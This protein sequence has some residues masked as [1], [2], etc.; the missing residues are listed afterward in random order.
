MATTD[1]T[2]PVDW[3]VD[4]VVHFLCHPGPAPWAQSSN[5]PRP[6]SAKLEATLRDNEMCGEVLMHVDND[7]LKDMG[8]K[9]YGHRIS[10]MKAVRW[11]QDKSPKYKSSQR[12]NHE[13]ETPEVRDRTQTDH[14]K[15]VPVA[16]TPVIVVP[17][18]PSV[19]ESSIVDNAQK[20]KRRIAPS[21]VQPDITSNSSGNDILSNTFAAQSGNFQPPEILA[22]LG[23]KAP[24]GARTQ[25]EEDF[26]EYLTQKYHDDDDDTSSPLPL[27]G[28]SESEGELDNETYRAI[29][30]DNPSLDISRPILPREQCKALIAEY[31]AEKEQL[32]R[33]KSLP[34][35]L[36]KARKMWMHSRQSNNLEREKNRFSADIAHLE[37]RLM[38][39]QE[40]ILA[41]EYRSSQTLQKACKN[42]DPTISDR[43]LGKWKL[44]TLESD[45]CPSKIPHRVNNTRARVIREVDSG[46]DET[47]DSGTE[48]LT[49]DSL[50]EEMS[51]D[52]VDFDQ[53]DIEQV[54]LGHETVSVSI[55]S[56]NENSRAQSKEL[57]PEP[58]PTRGFPFSL[59]SSP[60]SSDSEPLH[61]LRKR[62]RV[63]E[64]G[65]S[66]HANP[67]LKAPPTA[68]IQ[69]DEDEE[70]LLDMDI[71]PAANF[72]ARPSSSS[73]S[74]QQQQDQDIAETLIKTPPL[75][76]VSPT[77]NVDRELMVKTPPLNPTTPVKLT[78]TRPRPPEA[79]STKTSPSS[80]RSS[81]AR[82][83][84]I[85]DC[86]S[87]GSPMQEI[88]SP[89]DIEHA[90]LF[91]LLNGTSM[92]MIMESKDRIQLLAKSV[93]Q[94]RSSEIKSFGMFLD[95]WFPELYVEG[96]QEAIRAMIQNKREMQ[97][98]D[99]ED[100]KLFMRLAAL[101]VSWFHCVTL[102]PS[103]IDENLLDQALKAIKPGAESTFEIFY[104]K[105]KALVHAYNKWNPNSS[106]RRSTSV[107]SPNF[108]FRFENHSHRTSTD[109]DR[110]K[111]KRRHVIKLQ[112]NAQSFAQDRKAK[113]DRAREAFRRDR[114]RL[115]LSNSDPA[116]QVV[117]FKE[118]ILYLNPGIGEFVK[119][120]QLLG[121]QFMW[122][123]L[124]EGDNMQGCLLAHVMGL[125]KTMQVISLLVTIAEAAASQNPKI[126][127]QVP[128]K[129]H[130]SQTL[131]LCP[132]SLSHN[133]LE[134]LEFWAPPDHYLG[135]FYDINPNFYTDAPTRL[136]ILEAWKNN[137]GIL[138]LSYDMFRR[139]MSSNSSNTFDESQQKIVDN[140]LLSTPSIVVADEAHRLKSGVSAISKAASR[141]KTTS[142]IA[143]TGS[144][145]ANNLME[146]FQMIDWIAPGYLETSSAFKEK[147]VE[148]IQAG[149]YLDSTRSQRR[150]GLIALKL[151]NMIM[152][153]KVNRASIS[154]IAS[155]LPTK[156]EFILRVPLTETQKAAYNMFVQETKFNGNLTTLWQWLAIMQLCC[157]HPVPFLEK[158]KDRT[159]QN[160]DSSSF[161]PNSI[162]E[163]GLPS[164]LFQKIETIFKTVP[165]LSDPS[166]SHRAV[167]LGRI[168]EESKKVGDKV[169]IFTQSIPTV[170]YLDS[171][172]KE[173]HSS[174]KRIDGSTPTY[175]RQQMTKS[176]N[177][178]DD[179]TQV[180]LISTRAGGLGLNMFGA[181]RVIIFDFLFNPTWE[182]QAIGRAYRLGQMKPV[183]VYRFVAAGTFEDVIHNKVVFK[184][185]LSVRVVD[186]KNVLREG[187]KKK[188]EYLFFVKEKERHSLQHVL[189]K[190]PAVLDHIIN[191]DD[192]ASILG[193]TLSTLQDDENDRLTEQERKE[194]DSRLALDKLRRTDPQGYML[195]VQRRD[196]EE[197]AAMEAARLRWNEMAR[198]QQPQPSVADRPILPNGSQL[199]LPQHAGPIQP[200]NPIQ[201]PPN[202]YPNA[203]ISLVN[204]FLDSQQGLLERQTRQAEIQTDGFRAQWE[205]WAL[206]QQQANDS[207]ATGPQ[208]EFPYYAE[209][210]YLSQFP[211]STT[212]YMSQYGTENYNLSSTVPEL[213]DTDPLTSDFGTNSATANISPMSAPTGPIRPQ[214]VGRSQSFERSYSPPE[215]IPSFGSPM[216][217]STYSP[218]EVMHSFGGPFYPG[219]NMMTDGSNDNIA[220]PAS[221]RETPHP[222]PL[223]EGQ[224]RRASSSNT[225]ASAD[226]DNPAPTSPSAN[227]QPNRQ[228]SEVPAA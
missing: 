87:I 127:A 170:N 31:T 66:R 211:Q 135:T 64:M 8:V 80:R 65:Q 88:H 73:R 203:Q 72:T 60:S 7:G 168:L 2:D 74:I 116:G 50:D 84:I 148:P 216:D 33:Q 228:L 27:Y 154:A 173:R 110:L 89:V 151:L 214:N 156:T 225:V 185:Q 171:F 206:P 224:R 91:D 85:S 92:E 119:P 43:C 160:D 22:T 59:G 142:R 49:D 196:R 23:K 126:R 150:A 145:L 182:E 16:T 10:L 117:S 183:F 114:E 152:D 75:N 115:G 207:N 192:A 102:D 198:S 221:T 147:F 112:N 143:M 111:R 124:C 71:D 32:W 177:R 226:I 79:L 205:S 78:L 167:L 178:D 190:D 208:Q 122:R 199:T 184:S 195:E 136:A 63:V 21:L 172:L 139:L 120:H 14:A 164:S 53:T 4:Q 157:N 77:D 125:G 159:K 197:R 109:P 212:T 42:M 118:P 113:Q 70:D 86:E 41:F 204:S 153:P 99:P 39:Q 3:S 54:D 191:S 108:D 104:H 55:Y 68:F 134:E 106:R 25:K 186:K 28:E 24:S 44:A 223:K 18:R 163:A 96:V 155:D 13:N 121:I 218:P 56:G 169:L 227:N 175:Y 129:F 137:G 210:E 166:L 193:I 187:E 9:A 217:E 67:P 133:W 174:Y 103:G 220:R 26:L 194:V 30:Q 219:A 146:Y 162:A 101:F 1:K 6:D 76:P 200:Q 11:L 209:N 61:G 48:F 165:N 15:L 58:A 37:S 188:T 123:E 29:V 82:P 149:L 90:E 46:D 161:M 81:F 144:P 52:E 20:P 179:D 51:S 38:K 222:S 69:D 138:V 202:E 130:K 40:G 180:M 97:Y 105:F 19:Q 131:I 176:F 141:I 95:K 93:M 36:P 213:Q 98:K 215:I 12:S 100:S 57:R 140:I 107:K 5:T 132:S 94:L 17:S 47:L 201:R 181:N 34:K 45:V 189:G 35:E 158:L 62:Q 83:I 128:Q